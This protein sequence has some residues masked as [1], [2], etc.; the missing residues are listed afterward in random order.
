MTPRAHPTRLMTP[1]APAIPLSEEDVEM[2]IGGLWT[3]IL[4]SSCCV[5]MHVAGYF[6]LHV[7]CDEEGCAMKN[8]III[9]A[10]TMTFP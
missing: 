6:I 4:V 1:P 2:A 10:M 9:S 7:L 5:R 8:V 3:V